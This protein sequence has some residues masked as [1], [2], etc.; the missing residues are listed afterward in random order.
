MQAT[1][2]I[3]DDKLR[4]SFDE[5]LSEIDY[6]AI[7]AAGFTFWHG[8]KLFVAKWSVTAED[9]LIAFGFEIEDDDR[10]DDVEARVNRFSDYA[11]N[12][13]QAA[14]SAGS[15]A[16]RLS[17]GEAR[18]NPTVKRMRDATNRAQSEGE[19]AAYWNSRIARAI[20]HANYKEQPG[21]ISRRIEKLEALERKYTKET[22][23]ENWSPPYGLIDSTAYVTAKRAIIERYNAGEIASKEL[24][25]TEIKALYES[26]MGRSDVVAAWTE[27]LQ[28][29]QRSLDHV[30]MVLAYQRELY[31]QSGGVAADTVTLEIDGAVNWRGSWARIV[32]LNRT[33]VIVKPRVGSDWQ[34]KIKRNEAREI[35]TAAE[36]RER[37]VY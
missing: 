5:R 8:S 26:V 11:D 14:E 16:E 28:H 34:L 12:A 15:Y 21:V 2:N 25:Q 19:R 29:S 1:Y 13:E 31:K 9:A 6:K 22:K 23:R 4:A 32:K 7:K 20:A 24:A 18:V 33:T 36:C 37:I 10:P 27:Y 3:C 35:M 17:S 30:Q